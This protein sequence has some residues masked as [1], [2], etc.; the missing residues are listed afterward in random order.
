MS[1]VPIPSLS[2][3]ACANTEPTKALCER[4][5]D[6]PE[7]LIWGLEHEG[8]DLWGGHTAGSRRQMRRDFGIRLEP[9]RGFD[10][11]VRGN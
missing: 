8:N 9:I 5:Y 4:C 1:A 7:C 10:F 2:N 11:A 6:R 3:A